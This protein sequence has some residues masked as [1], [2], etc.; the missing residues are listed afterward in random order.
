MV[1]FQ[2][3]V[4]DGYIYVD[5]NGIILDKQVEKKDC[6]LIVGYKTSDIVIGN[7]VNDDDIKGLSDVMSIIQ[8]AE[9]N[10]IMKDITK[11]DIS[12]HDD[13]I[14]H[15]DSCGKLAHIG[16]VMS[17][18]DKMARVA[19]I[20]DE[21]RDYEGEIFVNVDFNNGEYSYFRGKV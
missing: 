17:I 15:F 10:G 13:Y 3:Q 11:I 20:L 12:N 21:E 1:K 9:N 16:D 2:L 6:V 5:Q 7:K 19:K 14:V 18:N 4:D 8:E